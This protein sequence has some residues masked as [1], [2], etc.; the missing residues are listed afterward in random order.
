MEMVEERVETGLA[1]AVGNGPR[2]LEQLL[3]AMPE[4][5]LITEGV[6]V[7]HVN[8][9]FER[10]FGYS[11]EGCLGQDATEMLVPEGRMHESEML[12]HLVNVEGCSEMET[13]RRTLCGELVDVALRVFRVHLR[14]G[15][16]GMFVTY[17]DI[18][19]QKQEEARLQHTALHDALTGL[20]NR[21]L[22]LDRVR[23][24]LA[25]LKRRPD[26]G[27]AVMFLD[28]DGFKKV[29]DTLGHAAGDQ[30]LLEVAERLKR[31]VRPQDAV[32][33]FGGD[34]FALLLDETASTEEVGLVAQRIAAEI[35]REV[36]ILGMP[37]RVGASM[38]IAMA[39]GAYEAAEALL[40]DADL[41]MYDAKGAGKGR[42]VVWGGQAGGHL[43]GQADGHKDHAQC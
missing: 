9:Q 8:Q 5:V 13:V 23:L 12:M 16:H 39:T 10:M 4:A 27:F 17:R 21:A 43:H 29:N 15:A 42:Y 28:L 41:A 34:E 24:T 31:C 25:R 20:P 18:R 30:V 6:R 14:G 2:F 33:R 38:G 11:L 26:R 22:F 3:D 7:V 19:R 37:V 40:H 35:G 1:D 36:G 32:A